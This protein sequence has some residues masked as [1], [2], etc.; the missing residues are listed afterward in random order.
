[1]S[2][3][4]ELEERVARLERAFGE[5][6]LV[7]F[8]SPAQAAALTATLEAAARERHARELARLRELAAR[9][10]RRQAA[11]PAPATGK[12]AFHP[13]QGA[14][15]RPVRGEEPGPERGRVGADGDLGDR[16]GGAARSRPRPLAG[17]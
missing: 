16:R 9:A 3:R 12:R 15:D 1:V 5:E 14:D 11:A 13:R 2:A 10:A 6:E 7:R 17:R 8:D 4:A